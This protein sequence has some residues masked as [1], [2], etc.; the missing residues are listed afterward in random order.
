MSVQDLIVRKTNAHFCLM[1]RLGFKEN[2]N[3][4]AGHFNSDFASFTKF[5]APVEALNVKNSLR[6]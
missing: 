6:T 4:N 2:L 1:F 5:S 3:A